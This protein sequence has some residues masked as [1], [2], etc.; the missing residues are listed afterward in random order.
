M[1]SP[2]FVH[3]TVNE[4]HIDDA[5][6]D[7]RCSCRQTPDEITDR[8]RAEIRAHAERWAQKVNREGGILLGQIVQRPDGSIDLYI[9][10]VVRDAPESVR[11]GF[12]MALAGYMVMTGEKLLA[13]IDDG[14]NDL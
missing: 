8:E 12:K 11:G 3:G 14:N 1:S 13:Q 5:S 9:G 2:H 4:G 10:E 7:V 6:G